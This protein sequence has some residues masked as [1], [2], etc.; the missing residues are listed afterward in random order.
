MSVPHSTDPKHH[1][2]VTPVRD[3]HK[4]TAPPLPRAAHPS[5]THVPYLHVVQQHAVARSN[6]HHHAVWQ[7]Y[8]TAAAATVDCRLL[9]RR[10][11]GGRGV[12]GVCV[13]VGGGGCGGLEE[14]GAET[15]YQGALPEARQAEH[16]GGPAT[17]A[18]VD[19]MG[20]LLI[21]S[22]SGLCGCAVRTVGGWKALVRKCRAWRRAGACDGTE[23]HPEGV[24]T[25]PYYCNHLPRH[26]IAPSSDSP[27]AARKDVRCARHWGDTGGPGGGGRGWGVTILILRGSGN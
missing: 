9:L 6:R 24:R 11:R 5:H 3:P 19:D 14:A 12:A 1:V 20:V 10:R 22:R 21:R 23:V 27:V 4:T 2:N 18:G 26:P 16:R 25:A 13:C 7:L 17:L 15:S 8:D